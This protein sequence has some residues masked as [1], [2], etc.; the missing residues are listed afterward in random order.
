VRDGLLRSIVFFLSFCRSWIFDLPL[1]ALRMDDA[2]ANDRPMNL[3]EL[4]R[5]V[6]SRLAE[7]LEDAP[8]VL[9][10]GPRQC[11]KTTLALELG[12]EL[13]YEYLTLDDSVTLGSAL[14]DPVSFVDALPE[15]VILDEVQR[16]PE[17]F[18]RIKWTVDRKRS[19]GRFLLTGSSNVL[20]VPQLADSLAGRMQVVRLHPLAQRELAS[21]GSSVLLDRLFSAKFP[22]VEVDRLG[23]E[24]VDRVVAGG[25]PP[26]LARPTAARRTRW[27]RD[28]VDALVQRDVRDLARIAHLEALPKILAAAAGSTAQLLNLTALGSALSITRPTL[29]EYLTLLERVFLLEEVPAWHTNRLTRLVKTP[30]LHL[31]DTGLAAVLAGLDADTLRTDRTALGPLLETFVFGELSRLASAEEQ[32]ITFHHFRDRDGVEVDLVLERGPR[33]IAGVEVKAGAT[34]TSRDFA[35]LTKLREATGAAF[36]AGVVFYDGNQIATF[37]DRLF[38]VPLRLMWDW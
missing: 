28:Y 18:L 14:A 13:G 25:F 38:A 17:L 31:T 5:L 6:S 27:Y 26:A 15:R 34:V 19:A 29:R 21:R 10:H 32:P 24:L 3:A 12:R 16:A 37:G 22:R 4:P 30:K 1:I 2:S 35:G 36:R 33:Q 23:G 11:G 7:A 20:L 8:V 9:I